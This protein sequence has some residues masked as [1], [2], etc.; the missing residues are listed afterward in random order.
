MSSGKSSRGGSSSK[1]GR[2]GPDAGPRGSGQGRGP[3]PGQGRAVRTGPGQEAPQVR[4]GTAMFPF[5]MRRRGEGGGTAAAAAGW[6]GGRGRRAA[7]GKPASS[8][9]PS[10]RGASGAAL[11][12]APLRAARNDIPAALAPSALSAWPGT[13]AQIAAAA[14]LPAPPSPVSPSLPPSPWPARLRAPPPRPRARLCPRAPRPRS[15]PSLPYWLA[16]PIRIQARESCAPAVVPAP[17]ARPCPH[18]SD[19][20]TPLG[21][22]SGNSLLGSRPYDPCGARPSTGLRPGVTGLMVEWQASADYRGGWEYCHTHSSSSY[23][24]I[25]PCGDRGV[26]GVGAG[27]RGVALPALG[28][29]TDLGSPASLGGS[30]SPAAQM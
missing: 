19:Q 3:R 1:S 10:P 27:G 22:L 2:A 30:L 17:S 5:K 25:S 6:R 23:L 21:P 14:N 15:P 24:K 11:A 7:G 20:G 29:K 4:A 18:T 28:R 8:P 26:C 16:Q 13:C 12:A 9:P